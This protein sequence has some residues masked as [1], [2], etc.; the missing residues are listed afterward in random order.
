M[1]RRVPRGGIE[2]SSRGAAG[3]DEEMETVLWHGVEWI[4]GEC[5]GAG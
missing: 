3:K 5:V 1:M 2:E 4:L